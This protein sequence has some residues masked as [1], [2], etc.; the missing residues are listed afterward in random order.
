MNQETL[1]QYFPMPEFRP[2]QLEILSKAIAAFQKGHK[3]FVAEAPVG[4]GK[5]PVGFALLQFFRSGYYVTT[6]KILQDQL[7]H[8]F[9]E[10]GK[11]LPGALRPMIDLKGRNAYQCLY[12]EN[13]KPLNV[14]RYRNCGD[15]APCVIDGKSKLEKCKDFCL[16]HLQKDKALAAPITL[17]NFHSF[18]F[19]ATEVRK[20]LVIDECHRIESTLMSIVRLNLSSKELYRRFGYRLQRK[21]TVAEYRTLLKTELL[22]IVEFALTGV[23]ESVPIDTA[24][25]EELTDLHKRVVRFLES[26]PD[27]WVVEIKNK[28][29]IDVTANLDQLIAAVQGGDARLQN[30]EFTAALTPVTVAE[31]AEKFLF[32]FADHVLLMS[33]TILDLRSFLRGIDVRLQEKNEQFI[34]VPTIFPVENR[35]VI[36]EYAAPTAFTFRNKEQTWP[37]MIE[38]ITKICS[39]HSGERGILHAHSHGLA[40]YIWNNI[41]FALRGRILFQGKSSWEVAPHEKMTFKEGEDFEGDRE[42][43]LDRHKD[44]SNSII[45]APAMNE[46]LDLHDDLGRFQIVCKIPWPGKSLQLDRREL[47]HPGYMAWLTAISFS[48]ALGRVVRHQKD[49]G[50]TYVI[51]AGFESFLQQ[52]TRYLPAAVIEALRYEEQIKIKQEFVE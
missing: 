6:Q 20:V 22:P 1:K 39:R 40:R 52:Y 43:L 24:D 34:Q 33:G 51:D 44:L 15:Q 28:D 17:F 4:I 48:Q 3:F 27:E 45:L 8:D 36:K 42:A 38:T 12:D 47:I 46:G 50:I 25:L 2:G 9:G 32:Q 35:R 21:K 11:W 18:M 10:G 49:W 16:Y 29:G 31:Y 41:G 30:E 26:N 7:I 23:R 13:F 14:Q 19:H 5:S 37:R